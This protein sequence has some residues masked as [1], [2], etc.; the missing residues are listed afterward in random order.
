MGGSRRTIAATDAS[1]STDEELV[2]NF[3]PKLIER[4]SVVTA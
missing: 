3:K 1:E 4:E 2:T